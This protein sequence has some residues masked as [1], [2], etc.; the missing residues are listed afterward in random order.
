MDMLRK[1]DRQAAELQPDVQIHDSTNYLVV[2]SPV[3][4]EPGRREQLGQLTIDERK[5]RYFAI[6]EAACKLGIE[7]PQ[8]IRDMAFPELTAKERLSM[9]FRVWDIADS[10]GPSPSLKP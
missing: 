5:Q 4:V 3:P 2:Q 6:Y 10:Y 8:F 7:P 1:S 9:V